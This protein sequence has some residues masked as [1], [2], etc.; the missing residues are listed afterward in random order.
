MSLRQPRRQE[1]LAEFSAASR[2]SIADLRPVRLGRANNADPSGQEVRV[3]LQ[4]ARGPSIPR[5][6]P[7]ADSRRADRLAP[8]HGLVLARVRDLAHV[9]G[10]VHDPVQ[11]ARQ[12]LKDLLARNAPLRAAAAEASSN[13]RRPKK[14]R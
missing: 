14:A 6:L 9:P 5:A 10:S 3:R 13:T 8:A 4:E 7:Q 1:P 2:S 11:A 12:L